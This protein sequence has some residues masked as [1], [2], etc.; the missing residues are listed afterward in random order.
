MV[1]WLRNNIVPHI[2]SLLRKLGI[3]RFW[4]NI[5]VPGW[6]ALKKLGL[7]FIFLLL[8]VGAA[9]WAYLLQQVAFPQAGSSGEQISATVYVET[10]PAH[11]NLQSMFTPS[12]TTNNLSFTVTVTGPTKRP[13]PW[14]LVVQCAAPSGKAYPGAVPLWSESPTGRQSTGTVL[15]RPGPTKK[16]L[17]FTCFTGLAGHDQT[18][19]TV[20]Q[21]RDLNLSLPV[22]EQN[23]VGESALAD[24]PLY[25]ETRAGK[26]QNV[27]EV[28]A[29][30]GAPCPISTPSPSSASPSAGSSS[31]SADTPSPSAIATSSPSP[32]ATTSPSSSV[33][34]SSSPEATL[35]PSSSSTTSATPSPNAVACYLQISRGAKSIKYSF[36]APSTVTTVTT[37][38]ILNNVTLSN[39]R[40]DSMYP[41][42]VITTDQVTWRGSAG[43][44]PSLSA[45]N[46]ASAERQ[47]K[48]AFWAGLLYGI[49]AALAV[50][51]FLEFY[52]AWQEVRNGGETEIPAGKVGDGIRND[53]E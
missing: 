29:V 8:A 43:L 44:S 33:T 13:D 9:T 18:A 47:N 42:G 19:A 53:H 46:L 34:S 24:A 30:P 15:V 35:S 5:A 20:V 45:T 28:Q 49:T 36:P 52:K 12:A 3:L 7:L 16:P 17:N 51:Y 50:P 41:Q 27:V 48:D 32:T 6:H 2:L 10:L 40:I 4:K 1:R 23:P 21:D 31:L 14:L 37:S 22:L 26:Y 25:A 11:V 39:E 38:E